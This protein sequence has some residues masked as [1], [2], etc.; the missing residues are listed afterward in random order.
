MQCQQARAR[1]NALN[2]QPSE[3]AKD[4]ELTEHLSSCRECASLVSAEM[5]LRADFMT[6]RQAEPTADLAVSAVRRRI[7]SAAPQIANPSPTG[8][9]IFE[10]LIA[11]LLPKTRTRIAIVVVVAVA[12]FIALV[13][14]DIRQK[15]GYQIAIDGV[16]KDIALDNPK[17]TSLLGA[18][19]MEQTEATNLLDSLGMNQI[20]FAVGECSET[21]RLTIFDLK[22][23]RDVQ[24]MVRAII[25]LG[26]CRIDNVAPVFRNE[27]MS[28]LG[29]ATRKLLS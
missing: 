26:C 2:W 14:L 1:L 3:Y 4:S 6:V 9:T 17:I 23:E 29:L 27:T 8:S 28:L 11:A 20:H 19:G 12:V 16:G 7:E 25:E 18:L 5:A 24:L 15:V 10:K 22:T 13:P 21:C